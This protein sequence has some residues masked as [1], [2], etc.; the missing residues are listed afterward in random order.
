MDLTLRPASL[1]EDGKELAALLERNTP[2]PAKEHAYWRHES[3]PA[4][5]GWSWVI[6]DR[7]SG[8][9]SAMASVLPRRVHV[10]GEIVVCGV[11]GDFVVDAA[12]RSLGPAV[13]LQRATFEP[14]DSGALAFCYDAVPHDRGMSTFV[15]LGM[16][17]SCEVIRHACPLRSDDYLGRRLGKGLWMKPVFAVTNLALRMRTGRRAMSGLE[18][19]ELDDSFGEEFTE[20]DKRVSSLGVIRS[21][22]SATD[23]TWRYRSTPGRRFR[24]L[25]ARGAGELRGFLAFLVSDNRASI[26]DLFG[27]HLSEVSGN[28]L[29]ALID[30]GRREGLAGIEGYL[31]EDSCLN[32][33]FARTGFRPRER[34]ARIVA[35][36]KPA[37]SILNSGARWSFGGCD[38]TQ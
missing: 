30:L 29:E 13:T 20:L 14:V 32:T 16:S 27:V 37:N 12:I 36:T 7:K 19:L 3:N 10:N 15:R 23:L 33:V 24:I 25:V 22:R 35:Y 17:P 11:V 9:I 6:C 5:P 31:S 1:S 28:L 18:V 4:G 8:M 38:I 2:G 34:A 21:G 26:M